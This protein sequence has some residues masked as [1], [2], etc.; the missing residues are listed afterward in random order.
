ME[1]NQR[2]HLPVVHWVTSLVTLSSLDPDLGEGRNEICHNEFLGRGPSPDSGER[3]RKWKLRPCW[4]WDRGTVPPLLVS[5]GSRHVL[6]F[7]L[8]RSLL[9][10]WLRFPGSLSHCGFPAWIRVCARGAGLLN[11]LGSCCSKQG[12]RPGHCSPTTVED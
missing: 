10:P 9:S 6:F 11:W 4:Q 2:C 5:I 8:C 7:T 3:P 12:M 1:Q